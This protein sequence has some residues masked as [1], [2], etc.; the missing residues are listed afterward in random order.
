MPLSLE[1]DRR[2][3]GLKSNSQFHYNS[4]SEVKEYMPQI[5]QKL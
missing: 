5:G 2:V 3:T 1:I 4:I